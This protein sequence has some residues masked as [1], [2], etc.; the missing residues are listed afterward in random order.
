MIR[1]TFVSGTLKKTR[2]QEAEEEGIGL[3]YKALLPPPAKGSYKKKKFDEDS[4]DDL[5][6]SGLLPDE[7]EES[8][9]D[10]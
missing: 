7:G 8:A 3:K 10:E 9:E 1:Q 2:D 6:G 5:S 4:H